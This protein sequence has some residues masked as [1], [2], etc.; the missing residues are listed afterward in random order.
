MSGLLSKQNS[1]SKYEHSDPFK[2][3]CSICQRFFDADERKKNCRLQSLLGSATHRVI[4]VFPVLADVVEVT[5][6]SRSTA[7]WRIHFIRSNGWLGHSFAQLITLLEIDGIGQNWE[8]SNKVAHRA[9]CI[10]HGLRKQ[11]GLDP[12]TCRNVSG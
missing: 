5:T 1:F 3:R 12:T 9:P 2:K 8:G 7:H 6:G 4:A 10:T 11:Y